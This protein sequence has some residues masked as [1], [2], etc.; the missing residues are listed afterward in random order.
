MVYPVE[1]IRETVLNALARST[2]RNR[3][4]VQRH[5]NILKQSVFLRREDSP[6]EGHWE[7][8]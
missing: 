8:R 1:A 3:K 5:L 2:G 7:V 6:K 4:T